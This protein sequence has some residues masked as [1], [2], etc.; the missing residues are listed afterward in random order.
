MVVVNEV[1]TVR[2][3]CSLYPRVILNVGCARSLIIIGGFFF[4][5]WDCSL[6]TGSSRERH[7]S[8]FNRFFLNWSY[9]TMFSVNTLVLNLDLGR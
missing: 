3:C 2:L 1:W 6:P 5:H 8:N 4:M 7:W 9:N